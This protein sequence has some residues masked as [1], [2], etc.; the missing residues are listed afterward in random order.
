LALGAAALLLWSAGL[1]TFVRAQA[2]E[3][4]TLPARDPHPAHRHNL[5]LLRYGPTVRASSYD[6]WLDHQH[7]PAFAVDGFDEPS[8]TEK[9]ASSPADRAPWL[10]VGWTTPALVDSV[11]LR[12]GGWKESAGQ[13]A[14]RY[15]LTCVGGATDGR[16]WLVEHNLEAEPSHTV[17]CEGATGLRLSIWPNGPRKVVRLYEIEVWGTPVEATGR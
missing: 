1:L 5:A 15:R 12:H 17:A 14:E 7:H 8:L 16:S 3:S 2:P 9:W 11:R 13:T 4:S 10:E 6:H